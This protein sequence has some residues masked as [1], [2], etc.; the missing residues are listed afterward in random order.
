LLVSTTAPGI[1]ASIPA[2]KDKCPVCGMFVSKY[3]DWTAIITFKDSS[4]LF[5]DG[6]KDMFI[7]YH[8]IKKF[9][10]NRKTA[11]ITSI[12][13]RDYYALKQIDAK[14]AWFVLGSDIYGPMGHELIPFAKEAEAKEFL[15]DHKG[16]K[17]VRFN[18][19]S[20]GLVKGL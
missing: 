10:P 4:S 20:A 18:E 13:V 12:T 9:T 16:K 3:P 2:P 5:F 8:A 11:D 15:R 19:V 6:A 17:I 1:A 14:T 7:Y